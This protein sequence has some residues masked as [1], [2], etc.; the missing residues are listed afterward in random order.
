MSEHRPPAATKRSSYQPL[1][2]LAAILSLTG[3]AIVGVVLAA[4]GTLLTAGGSSLASPPFGPVEIVSI[5]TTC[6]PNG[7]V[8]G[9]ITVRNRTQQPVSDQVPLILTDH[10]PPSRGGSPHFMPTGASTLANVTLG[11]GATATFS[12]GPLSTAGVDPDAN[13]LRVEVNTNLRPDLN[14]EKSAS[15]PPCGVSPTSTPT[16]TP[17]HT[18][19]NTPPPPTNTPVPTATPT[20][21]PPGQ[22][23]PTNTPPTEATPTDTP[24]PEATATN[25]PSAAPTETPESQVL[26]TIIAPTPEAGVSGFP[27]TGTGGPS[28]GGRSLQ[29]VGSLMA[30]AGLAG[31]LLLAFRR[32][33]FG[34]RR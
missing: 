7:A 27:P 19:T 6:G 15:F 34:Q 14:P 25:T 32:S 12:Y 10:V 24:G 17:T 1:R 11:P 8:S 9:T 16:N 5:T 18:P 21:T 31:G 30:M 28:S 20:N 33:R 13:S 29:V 2:A 22:P 26:A 4:A 3:F 23:T